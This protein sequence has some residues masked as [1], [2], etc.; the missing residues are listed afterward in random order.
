MIFIKWLN[1]EFEKKISKILG[2]GQ[3]QL[4]MTETTFLKAYAIKI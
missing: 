2:L 1:I 4:Q 3:K